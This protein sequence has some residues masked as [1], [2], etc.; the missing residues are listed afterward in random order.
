MER[1]VAAGEEQA[2]SCRRDIRQQVRAQR[3]AH[4]L[5]GEDEQEGTAGRLEANDVAQ[6][7]GH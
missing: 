7:Y 6:R 2:R 5:E 1:Q 3:G 4:R